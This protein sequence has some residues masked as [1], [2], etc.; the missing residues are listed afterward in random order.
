MDMYN[1]QLLLDGI[2]MG[3]NGGFV[4]IADE[5]IFFVIYTTAYSKNKKANKTIL[6]DLLSRYF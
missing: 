1:I 6:S 4:A 2:D 3:D 5:N